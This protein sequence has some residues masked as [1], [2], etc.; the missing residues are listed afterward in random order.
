MPRPTAPLHCSI[1]TP[2][3]ALQRCELQA[4]SAAP[5]H[6]LTCGLDRYQANFLGEVD[7]VALYAGVLSDGE[8]QAM[9]RR[10]LNGSHPDLVLGYTFDTAGEE[11][12]SGAPERGSNPRLADH[13]F[14]CSLRRNLIARSM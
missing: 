12:L 7:D 3:A 8:L 10:P 5:D 11:A 1:H 2:L 9:W 14:T 4:S 6:P 13:G